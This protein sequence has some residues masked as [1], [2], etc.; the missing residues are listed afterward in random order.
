MQFW[1]ARASGVDDLPVAPPLAERFRNDVASELAITRGFSVNLAEPDGKD[2]WRV[3]G[4]PAEI[5]NDLIDDMIPT[6]MRG[7]TVMLLTQNAPFYRTRLTS[8]EHARDELVSQP[9]NSSG[10]K[11][12]HMPRRGHRF[13]RRGLL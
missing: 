4:P 1:R 7:H 3:L 13:H 8:A 11:R 10:A 5:V 9:T 6:P 2:S 12:Y